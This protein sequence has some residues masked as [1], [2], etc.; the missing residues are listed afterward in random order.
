MI[1]YEEFFSSKG[2]TLYE[3]LESNGVKMTMIN[4]EWYNTG[5]DLQDSAINDLMENYNPWPAE[6][7]KKWEEI[8]QGFKQALDMLVAGSL[9]TERNSWSIQESEARA[10]TLDN[11]VPTPALSTLSYARGIPLN[12]LVAKVIEKA[13]LYK[14]YYFYF[15]GIRDKLE[16]SIKSFSDTDPL[17]K[18]EELRALK[19]EVN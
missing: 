12:V 16:D 18:L 10:W 13:D 19:Y 6:K 8:Q 11:T 5:N 14:Q 4:G 3:F 1:R 15:Q 7:R 9:D 17:H 2:P